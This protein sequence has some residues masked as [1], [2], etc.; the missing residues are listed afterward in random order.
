MKHKMKIRVSKAIDPDSVVSV[1][2]T[3]IPKRLWKKLFGDTQKVTI[4][5]PGDSVDAISIYEIPKGGEEG[6]ASNP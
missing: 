3:S 4:V 5:V 6:A 1:K 2:K